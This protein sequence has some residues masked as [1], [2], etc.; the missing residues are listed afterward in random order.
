MKHLQ[1][2]AHEDGELELNVSVGLCLTDACMVG[3]RGENRA[4]SV[5]MFKK[6]KIYL[7]FYLYE[8]TVAAFRRGHWVS[9]QIVVNQHVFVGN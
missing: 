8:Y 5:V 6:T 4:E 3:S 2:A 9:L 1:H 7:L